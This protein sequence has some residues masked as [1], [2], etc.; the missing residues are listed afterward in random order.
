MVT[1]SS[2]EP[3]TKSKSLRTPP[4]A[5]DNK[6]LLMRMTSWIQTLRT[7]F[8]SRK[9]DSLTASRARRRVESDRWTV[10]K[11]EDRS[12]LSF[13]AILTP[14]NLVASPN[15]PVSFDIQY[16][17]Q[18][19]SGNPVTLP[20]TGLALSTFFDSSQLTFQV[21]TNYLQTHLFAEAIIDAVQDDVDN[22]DG[23]VAT[24]KFFTVSW[25]SFSNNF[26]TGTQPATLFTANFT[27]TSNFAGS[28]LID[29]GGSP[30]T[31]FELK[32]APV[33]ITR[34]AEASSVA[35]SSSVPNLTS[36]SPIPV[37]VTFSDS[38]NGFTAS[39]LVLSG[40][41]LSNFSGN[42]ANYT[43]DL[44][45]TV[46]GIV[47]VNI[48]A[49]VATNGTGGSNLAAPQF[50]RVFDNQGPT[51]TSTSAIN[52]VENNV[53]VLQVTATDVHP[54]IT[55]SLS[56][57]VD[58]S[59]FTL[60]STTG[61]LN[62]IA[63]PQFASPTD[64]GGNNVYDVQVTAADSLGNQTSQNI[65]VTVTISGS[66]S[67][68]FS[69]PALIT[70]PSSGIASPYPSNITVS[71]LVGTI[72]DVNVTLH[73]LTHA[74][75]G[76][77]DIL[78][79]SPSGQSVILMSDVGGASGV[80][81]LDLAFDD[82]AASFLSVS[83]RLVAGTFRPSNVDTSDV[84]PAPAPTGAPTGATLDTFNSTNPNGTWRLFVIDDIVTDAGF[85]GEG[86][87]LTITT[88]NTSPTIGSINQPPAIEVNSETQ[89]INLTG[90]GA[91]GGANRPLAVTATSSNAT[92]IANPVV[93]YTSPNSTGVLSYTPAVD[94]FGESTITVMVR[95]QQTGA[96]VSRSFV[97]T[98]N[99]PAIPLQL[100]STPIEL[101]YIKRRPSITVLPNVTVTGRPFDGATLTVT[102]NSF[103]RRKPVDS[104]SFP[105]SFSIGTTT[106][107]T[108]ANFQIR[109]QITLN[110]GV[111]S[112]QV[113]TFLRG[114]RFS[115]KG[116]GLSKLTRTIQVTLTKSGQNSTAVT[117]VIN[118]RKK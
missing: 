88:D 85:I 114:I 39:D 1:L 43:F 93:N 40:G 57:G 117:Q 90:I 41:T 77:I 45:P 47:T 58:V 36:T 30:G 99:P 109:Q 87:T 100:E 76:D 38:V 64:V 15:S 9:P 72:V 104:L 14:A 101:T 66:T 8:T 103:G 92:L 7:C 25:L 33:T 112:D 51:L 106:G 11:L 110:A 3:F 56:G 23:N 89:T 74:F 49:S 115:T 20:S 78:L 6:A 60:N 118:V 27:A 107:I 113:Q 95:D 97:V 55:Y 29:F 28:T 32:S 108:Y 79:V 50:T 22:L 68:S 65:A 52:V 61:Q 63:A 54:A 81:N 94:Q 2:I 82:S 24:D 69:N 48:H 13:Q 84:F 19:T 75:P 5:V 4:S 71:E 91:A 34:A 17:T 70:I 42:G 12:L 102:M 53:S 44:T 86:W 59:K 10:E 105:S 16:Q 31:N 26:P 46:Q 21:P 98:V 96:E 73:G 62:F 80:T 37:V 111:T 18:D 116:G 35:I 67:G 83:D